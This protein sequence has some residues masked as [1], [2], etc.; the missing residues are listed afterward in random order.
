MIVRSPSSEKI[1]KPPESVSTG[2]SHPMNAWIP[3]TRSNASGPG[4]SIRWYVFPSTT[5]VP[6]DAR[7]AGSSPVTVARV[8]TVM[9]AG[10]STCPCEVTSAPRRALV[11]ASRAPTLKVRPMS[12]RRLPAV[13]E[14]R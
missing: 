12:A 6:T 4:R 9:N 8:P 3:P 2:P 10:V 5:C 14:G 1:W 13:M 7:S 11:P